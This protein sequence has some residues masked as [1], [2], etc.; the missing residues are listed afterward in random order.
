LEKKKRDSKI[1]SSILIHHATANNKSMIRNREESR[2]HK[3]E[4]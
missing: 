1:I 3:L 4:L 2:K